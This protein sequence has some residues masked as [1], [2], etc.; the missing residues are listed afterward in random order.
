MLGLA[1]AAGG[2]G[3]YT[4]YAVLYNYGGYWWC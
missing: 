2:G 1:Y 3:I 4:V